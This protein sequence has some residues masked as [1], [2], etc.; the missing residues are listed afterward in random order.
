MRTEGQTAPSDR[1]VHRPPQTERITIHFW[2]TNIPRRSSFRLTAN[3]LSKSNHHH[4]HLHNLLLLLL[5][6]LLLPHLLLLPLLLLTLPLQDILRL[7]TVRT[8]CSLVLQLLFYFSPDN[9][10]TS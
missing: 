2:G 8:I 9:T 6:L 5:L 4:H 1:D 3:A 7:R 10:T